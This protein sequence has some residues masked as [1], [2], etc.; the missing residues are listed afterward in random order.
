MKGKKE[1]D[2][3]EFGLGWREKRKEIGF[4]KSASLNS[5]SVCWG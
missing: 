4:T 5:V 3:R 1:T 2:E